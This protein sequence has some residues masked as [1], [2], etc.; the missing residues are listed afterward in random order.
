MA[1]RALSR[2]DGGG[3]VR[4]AEINSSRN[5]FSRPRQKKRGKNLKEPGKRSF[6]AAASIGR[7]FLRAGT[8]S[9]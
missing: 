3:G 5:L 9:G 2:S 4:A 7:L 1:E 6:R 8:E